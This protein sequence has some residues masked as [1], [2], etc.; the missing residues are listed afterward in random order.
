[1]VIGKREVEE[2]TLSIRKGGGK[3]QGSLT[4]GNFISLL[5]AEEK[6]KSA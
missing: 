1:V 5:D 3:D 2:G 4:L 6:G